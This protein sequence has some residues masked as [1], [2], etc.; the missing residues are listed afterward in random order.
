MF[1]NLTPHAIVVTTT[2]HR[3]WGYPDG[4]DW[5]QGEKTFEPSGNVARVETTYKSL[6]PLR[7]IGAQGDDWDELFLLT[8]QEFGEITELP[9]PNGSVFIVSSIVLNAATAQGR[10]DCVAPD[11]NNAVRNKSG[12]IVSV[13]G[14]VKMKNKS[15]KDESIEQLADELAVAQGCMSKQ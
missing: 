8:E 11:T 12:H 7:L 1:V 13:P 2:I 3:P 6:D 15:H 5:H 9:Q 14:F 4:E 10:T